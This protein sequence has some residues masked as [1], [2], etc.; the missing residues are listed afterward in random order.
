MATPRSCYKW[1]PDLTTW[2]NAKDL[3]ATFGAE[4]PRLTTENTADR[5]VAVRAEESW[6]GYT[7]EANE[8]VWVDRFGNEGTHLNWAGGEPNNNMGRGHYAYL[9]SNGEV[10]DVSDTDLAPHYC[11][12][13]GEIYTVFISV[14]DS[15]P[16]SKF[17]F[18]VVYK[19]HNQSR[20]M[21]LL[22]KSV[23]TRLD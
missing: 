18:Y 4:L 11:V 10:D 2:L 19:A 8:G 5:L 9:Y 17:D 21:R 3:C 7:D 15:F 16:P 6:L 20:I 13:L 22:S 23:N 14:G 1:F 12:I